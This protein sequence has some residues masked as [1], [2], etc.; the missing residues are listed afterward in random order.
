[1]NDILTESRAILQTMPL[2][3]QNLAESLPPSLL[4][5]PPAEGE[6]S[7]LD[8]LQHLVDTERWV[9]PVR[10]AGIGHCRFDGR[11]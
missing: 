7:A 2:R 9:F 1:M 3:W 6:W 8:C 4:D 11:R 10:V 5:L